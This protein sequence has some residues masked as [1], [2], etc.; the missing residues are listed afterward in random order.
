V[1][2]DVFV[3]LRM[4]WILS[5]V[6]Q[7]R[8]RVLWNQDLMYGEQMKQGIMGAAHLYDAIAYVSAY[9]RHQWE[10]I[11]PEL[12]PIGYTTRNGY[13]PAHVP[14]NVEKVPYRIIHCSRPERGLTPL[15]AMWP[16]LKALV[17]GA[18]LQICRYSSMYDPT[19]WGQVCAAYDR[20][21]EAVQ[22]QVGGITF[23]GELP[24]LYRAIAE[25]SV[26]WYPGVVDFG[27]TSCIAAIE[28]QACGTAFVGSFK[29]ALPETVPYGRLIVGDARV[30]GLDSWP[31]RCPARNA[32]TRHS[33]AVATRG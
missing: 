28:A 27:E 26:M 25:A 7:A 2:W 10:T 4:S 23:L 12:A 11:V 9:H 18:E 21:V 32:G 16:A 20:A 17:P 13:D 3:A 29:G 30:G 22:Q 15:L 14:A 24:E 8:F 5:Q 6:P 31:V 33:R 19:G 1:D